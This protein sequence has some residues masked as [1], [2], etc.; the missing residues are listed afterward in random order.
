M[1]NI[2]FHNK[3]VSKSFNN[4][5]DDL[6]TAMPSFLREDFVPVKHAVPVNITETEAGYRLDLVAP[7]FEKENFRISIDN[8]VLT[9]EGESKATEETKTEKMIRKEHRIVN[10]KRS[11]T[12]DEQ[13]ETEQIGAQ[14]VNGILTLN[15]PRKAEVRNAAKQITIQ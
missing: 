6:F 3:P 12:L 4:L 10:F 5:V 8:N 14:Y 13:I 1:T 7:G 9:I 2:R 11:F 15:F